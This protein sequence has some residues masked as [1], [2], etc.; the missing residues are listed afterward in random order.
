LYFFFPKTDINESIKQLRNVLAAVWVATVAISALVGSTIARGA[1]RPVRRAADESR[2]TALRLLGRT[3][4]DGEDEFGQW[5]DSFD[6]VVTALEAKIVELSEAA[7]R[8]RRFTADVAHELRTPLTGLVSAASLLEE[9]IADLERGARRPAELLVG[10]VRRLHALVTELLEMARLDAET[11]VV[12]TEIIDLRDTLES[13]LQQFA[14]R[15]DI[16]C[17]FEPAVQVWSD[18][19]RLK[20]IVVNLIQNALQHGSL[21]VRLRTRGEGNEARIDVIDSGPGIAQIDAT[22]VFERFYKADASRSRQGSGLG[23]AIAAGHANA[24]GG[25]LRVSNPGEP[26]ACFTLT[27]PRAAPHEEPRRSAPPRDRRAAVTPPK[28]RLFR[29]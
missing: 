23:L 12:E 14:G 26:G 3:S 5:A 29:G 11:D 13:A 10:D 20:R 15:A 6:A 19:V 24:I 27:L 18:R 25:A 9:H 22:R 28:S 17:D 21:E 8:E 7:E 2:L 1:L 16:V 4:A